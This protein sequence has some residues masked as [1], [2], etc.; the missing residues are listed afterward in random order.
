MEVA[1]EVVGEDSESLMV[2]ISS[3]SSIAEQA[4]DHDGSRPRDGPCTPF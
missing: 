4:M 2:Q 3:S 1:D